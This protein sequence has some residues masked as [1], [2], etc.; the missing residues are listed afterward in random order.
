MG[1]WIFPTDG[2]MMDSLCGFSVVNILTTRVF[3]WKTLWVDFQ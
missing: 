2:R 1:I 3:S